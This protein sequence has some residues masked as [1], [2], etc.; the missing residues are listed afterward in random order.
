[1]IGAYIFIDTI[2]ESSCN[3]IT[4]RDDIIATIHSGLQVSGEI[5]SKVYRVT[6]IG[7]LSDL[8]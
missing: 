3:E 5:G 7:K 1:M 6:K 8:I 4:K 2:T